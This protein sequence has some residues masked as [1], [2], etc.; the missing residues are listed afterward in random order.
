MS[1][2]L[3]GIA[4]FV[5]LVFRSCTPAPHDNPGKLPYS[6]PKTP[7]YQL[8]TSVAT[9]ESDLNPTNSVTSTVEPLINYQLVNVH[10]EIYLETRWGDGAGEFGYQQDNTNLKY[11]I[12]PDQPV[13]D[14]QGDMFIPDPNNDRILWYQDRTT[15][16]IQS[17]FRPPTNLNRIG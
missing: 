3:L 8:A 9:T 16:P 2:K 6:A 4:I 7:D 11:V 15:A 1:S 17:L 12:G 5:V 13:F 10:C 14:E